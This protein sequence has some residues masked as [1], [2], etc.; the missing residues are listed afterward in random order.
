[1]AGDRHNL[2]VIQAFPDLPRDEGVTG[3]AILAIEVLQYLFFPQ[4]VVAGSKF[5]VGID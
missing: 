2:F 3:P 1:M 5:P 4:R